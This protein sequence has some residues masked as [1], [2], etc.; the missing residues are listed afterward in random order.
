MLPPLA[1]AQMRA[2]AGIWR[3][4]GGQ[5]GLGVSRGPDSLCRAHRTQVWW[6]GQS[7]EVCLLPNPLPTALLSP[8]PRSCH[9]TPRPPLYPR[10][11]LP[12]G[13]S[14]RYHIHCIQQIL[15][16]H[17]LCAPGATIRGGSCQDPSRCSQQRK[18]IQRE[19][20]PSH[21]SARRGSPFRPSLS[22]TVSPRGRGQQAGG[23]ADRLGGHRAWATF[24]SPPSSVEAVIVAV[25]LTSFSFLSLPLPL[26]SW[27]H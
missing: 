20:G 26:P 6:P 13:A 16:E 23:G 14:H 8:C 27:G 18:G 12:T 4:S 9:P 1:L 3:C 22:S 25:F 19:G 17:L 15:K 5:E 21:W 2:G 11:T 7:L 24:E 10:Q